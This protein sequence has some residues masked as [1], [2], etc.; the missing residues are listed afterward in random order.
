MSSEEKLVVFELN[1][2]KFALSILGIQEII[3]LVKITNVPFAPNY[4]KGIINY[5]GHIISLINVSIYLNLPEKQI[6][7]ASRI[8]VI[9][10]EENLLGLLVDSVFEVSRYNPADVKPPECIGNKTEYTSGF[11]QQN[12]DILQLLDIKILLESMQLETER[13]VSL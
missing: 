9:E 3:C 13:R 10:H 12:E 7:Q 6:D 11:I 5:R 4:I 1:Q 8:I 2:Q